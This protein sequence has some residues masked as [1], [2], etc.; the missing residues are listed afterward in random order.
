[1]PGV[2]AGKIGPL[3]KTIGAISKVGR[4]SLDPSAGDLA[5]TAGWGIYQPKAGAVMPGSGKL[6]ERQCD[7][8]EAKA[9]G[10]EAAARGMSAKDVR[11]LL[12][13]KTLDVFLNGAAYWRN[14]PANVWD[15]RIGGYQVIKKWLSYREEGL[16]GRPLKTDEAREVTNMARRIAAILLLQPKLD[17]NYCAV[18]A[19]AYDWPAA[20]AG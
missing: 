20:V 6:S 12:G 10:D 18:K 9:I 8:S 3:L 13:D 19:A 4:G 7:D 14:I 5:V 16:L 15:Y 2:T 1:V 17:E 11:G